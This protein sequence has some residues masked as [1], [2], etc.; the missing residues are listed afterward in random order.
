[1]PKR[2]N[3]F[4]GFVPVA[5]TIRC[6]L[7]PGQKELARKGVYEAEAKPDT[8]TYLSANKPLSNYSDF[9]ITTKADYAPPQPACP[10]RWKDEPKSVAHWSSEYRSNYKHDSDECPKFLRQREPLYTSNDPPACLSQG[11]LHSSYN[12][13][14]G[15]EGYDIRSRLDPNSS[16]CPRTL[17]D[18]TAGTTTGTSHIPGYQGFLPV[19]SRNPRVSAYASGKKIKHKNDGA[20]VQNF[21]QNMPGYSGFVAKVAINDQ[22][23]RQIT[24]L[25]EASNYNA[26]YK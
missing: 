26:I 17:G 15:P 23:P 2:A 21:H 16:K 9:Q 12:A 18:L 11:Y 20:L 13:D 3:G 19:E 14:F 6:S 4:S 1:M 24:T 22:G 7:K 10:D 25:T 8:V 5:E